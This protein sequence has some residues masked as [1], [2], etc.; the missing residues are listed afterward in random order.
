MSDKKLISDFIQL[1]SNY[2]RTY[3]ALQEKNR[4]NEQLKTQM[5]R[6]KD[7]YSNLQK[8]YESLKQVQQ[9][10]IQAN[11]ELKRENNGLL[12]KNKQLQRDSLSKTIITMNSTTPVSS[13]PKK[14][15]STRSTLNGP[16]KQVQKRTTRKQLADF[17]VESL[18]KHRKWRGKYQYLVRWK[19]YSEQDDRWVTENDLNCPSLLKNYK[20]THQM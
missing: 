14:T 1:Q 19:N 15:P 12:A 13:K 17:E 2:H 18:I 20:R 4:E 11:C 9:M 3:F 6:L 16:S 8:K 5:K 10:D 7:D